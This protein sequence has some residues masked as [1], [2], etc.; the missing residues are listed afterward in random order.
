MIETIEVAK[1]EVLGSRAM[2]KI[3][4][5]G[6]IPAI[7]YGHGEANIC[8][9]LPLDT[10]NNLIKHG[11]KLVSLT[12][13]VVDTALLRSVQW[14]SMGDRVIHVD[15][16]RVSQ[17]ETVEVTLPI[18]LHGEAPG[19]MSAAGQLR[20]VTHEIVIS[21]PAASIPEY[22]VCEIGTLQIGQSIHV[23]EL[24]LPVGASPV[25]PGS[26]VI[27]QVIVASGESAGT[28]AA[29]QIE[30]ELIRKEKPAES[31]T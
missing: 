23:N 8:L 27:V 30:P 22:L 5:K 6:L 18:H 20:F 1:R 11:T 26:I 17:T 25:T 15:F 13:A 16:A 14:S 4:E 19:A 24:T 10:V 3:R 28:E 9:T 12:G 2:I 31:A 7:L 21:C 29:I